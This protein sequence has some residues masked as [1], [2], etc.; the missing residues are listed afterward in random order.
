MNLAFRRLTAQVAEGI[1]TILANVAFIAKEVRT[2]AVTEVLKGE[3]LG[4]CESL[5]NTLVFDVRKELETLGDKLGIHP[6]QEPAAPDVVNPDPQ[7]NIGFIKEWTWR[8][9]AKLDR[10]IKNLPK[11][12][13]DVEAAAFAVLLRESG[14]NILHAYARLRTA[15]DEISRLWS[16]GRRMP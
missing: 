14:A 3:V 12:T 10:V 1:D 13:K 15:T 11:E 2:I 9:I 16:D 5:R 4:I 7:V 8:E 6:G